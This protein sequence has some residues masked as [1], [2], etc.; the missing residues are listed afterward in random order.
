M[1]YG[2]PISINESDFGTVQDDGSTTLPLAKIAT[3]ITQAVI[4]TAW[5]QANVMRDD[6][7]EKVDGVTNAGFL[8]GS[9]PQ[10]TAN[11]VDAPSVSAPNVSIPSTVDTSQIMST[12]DDKYAEL[13]NLL[14]DRF[15]SFRA[16][17]FP[18]ESNAYVAAENWLQ[19]AIADP[20]GLPASVREQI[21][22]DDQARILADKGRAQDAVIA[23]FAARRF[24]LPPDVAASAVLQIE[25]K[26]QDLVAESSRKL[27]IMSID[28]QKFT[29]EK[30]L[31]LRG[32]A[33]DAAIKYISALAAGPDMASRLVGIGYDAQSK[34]ISA[35][36][37]FYRADV[38][39]KEMVSKVSQFNATTALEAAT[40][41]QMSTLSLIDK[42]VEALLTEAKSIASMAT[43]MY[44][45][46]HANAGVSVSI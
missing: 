37:D 23:Q 12:F 41:N 19:A 8:S 13:V 11:T 28:M 3:R 31:G 24:P 44:N 39:A 17:Y 45:N 14:S 18:D 16:T 42:R 4:N 10:I 40:K 29:V 1:S 46:L 43:S 38:S 21:M 6:L 22:A 20:S 35:A 36:A 27:T 32:A 25:Q 7:S 5:D 26:A 15:V 33:M 2:L 9:G 30:L 34:L